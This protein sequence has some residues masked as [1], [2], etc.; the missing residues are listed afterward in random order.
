MVR[1]A[2]FHISHT[3]LTHKS[4]ITLTG[5]HTQGCEA[6]DMLVGHLLRHVEIP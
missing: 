2:V 6:R 1:S 4:I 5:I 3:Q